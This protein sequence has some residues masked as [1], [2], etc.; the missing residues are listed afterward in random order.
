MPTYSA[1]SNTA[2]AET[3]PWPRTLRLFLLNPTVV[4]AARVNEPEGVGYP[5]DEVQFDTVTTGAYTDILPGMVVQFGTAAGGFDLGRQRIRKTPTA[6][7]LYIGRSSRGQRDGEADILDDTY[8]TVLDLYQVASKIPLI[9]TD[10]T[11]YKDSDIAYTDQ[12]IEPP[13]V[14]NCGPGMAGTVDSITGLLNVAFSAANSFAVADGATITAWAWNLGDGNVIAGDSDEE[15]V[16]AEFP[17][18]FRWVALTV[19]DSNGKVHT[20][21]CPV[22]ARDPDADEGIKIFEVETQ[23]ITLQGQQL[24][25]RVREPIDLADYPDGTIVMLWAGEPQ[26]ESDRS[27]MQFIGWIQQEP[28]NQDAQRTALLQDTVL[29]CVDVAGR[30]DLLPGFPQIVEHDAAPDNWSQMADAN[31]DRYLHYLLHW[32]S[33]ALELADWTWSGTGDA[34]PFKVLGSDGQSLF[35]QVQRRANALVPDHQF[36]CNRRGQLQ[37]VIDPLLQDDA[38]RT[39]TEQGSITLA[40]WSAVR[41]ER[42]RP[43][44]IH[45]LRSNAI[46][47][48]N[49]QVAALFCIAPGDAPGQGEQEIDHGEQLTISQAALNTV[50]GHRYARINAPQS[51]FTVTLAAGD[52]LGIEP[53]DLTWVRLIV[54]AA[55]RT[56][57]AAFDRRGLVQE[58]NIRYDHGRTG[59]T[60]T[61][62]MVWERETTGTPAVTVIPAA[63]E[64]VDDG[65]FWVPPP[66][67]FVPPTYGDPEVYY[68][69]P[70]GYV[71]WDGAHIMRTWDV[72]DSSPTWELIDSGMSGN[73]RDIQYVHTGTSTVGGWLMTDTAIYWCDN[74]LATTPTWTSKLAITTVRA[75]DATPTTGDVHFKTM[76][77]YPSEPG[78][79]CVATGPL[80][81]DTS[82]ATYPH[83]Y[84]WHTHDYGATWTQVDMDNYLVTTLGNTRGYCYTS[85]FGMAIFHTSPGT[86]YCVRATPAVGG[87]SSKRVFV[88]TDLGHTWTRTDATFVAGLNNRQDCSI[89]H[90]FPSATDSSYVTQGQLGTDQRLKLYL[91]ED[92]WATAAQLTDTDD[93]T[94]YGGVCSL[95]RVNKRTFDNDHALAWFRNTSDGNI[96]LLETTDQGATWASLYDSGLP[97][98]NIPNTG[99]ATNVT[100]APHATPN[101]WPPDTD[102]WFLVRAAVG[103]GSVTDVIMSTEDNFGTAP[104]SRVGNLSSILPGGA[105]GWTNGPAGGIALPRVGVNS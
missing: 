7:T 9:A 40:D 102:V 43:P 41:Y 57:G 32:H 77:H 64:P 96:H 47:A 4:F 12:T 89:L 3:F 23:R 92:E 99:V 74:L 81:G 27:H 105:S 79:L 80:A 58:L 71:L 8:I 2:S 38:D 48:R 78:Y 54:G 90:P 19:Q 29:N 94:G 100:T 6:D 14:A 20:A 103:S 42:T 31:M 61:V 88:S 49:D 33:T 93:P 53:A 26:S 63:A 5:V 76:A 39:A 30:L 35:D 91:S 1:Y 75:N 83:A 73:I 84:F 11:T 52:D 10:G 36:T 82:N 28:I 72:L 44:R 95:W 50:T 45:W 18:G 22:F 37:T 46:Q 25:V 56:P 85:L 65:D 68:G 87:N 51:K 34:Y 98:N 60:K 15:E 17:A 16:T 59:T 13:P 70:A 86:I 101:G 24:G 97:E 104:V 66:D 55:Q 69:A 62:E 67:D 21:R